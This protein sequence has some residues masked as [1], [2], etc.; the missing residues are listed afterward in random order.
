MLSPRPPPPRLLAERVL[1]DVPS[2][3]SRRLGSTTPRS[4]RKRHSTHAPR[5][6]S[7]IAASEPSR[8]G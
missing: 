5:V 1:A 3:T 8:G 2:R 6:A 4:E 7:A